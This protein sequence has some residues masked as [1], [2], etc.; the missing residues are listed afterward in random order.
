MK[1]VFKV[2]AALIDVCDLAETDG[3]HPAIEARHYN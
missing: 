1:K 3:H 2:W